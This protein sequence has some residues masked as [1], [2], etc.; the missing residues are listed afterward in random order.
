MNRKI[1]LRKQ[2]LLLLCILALFNIS[3]KL[4]GQSVSISSVTTK[5][6]PSSI[7]CNSGDY[8]TFKVN[9]SYSSFTDASTSMSFLIEFKTASG[10]TWSAVNQGSFSETVSNTNTSGS[11]SKDVDIGSAGSYLLRVTATNGSQTA[12]AATSSVIITVNAPSVFTPYIS[13]VSPACANST[14]NLSANNFHIFTTSNTGWSGNGL[15]GKNFS[16]TNKLPN[17]ISG[18]NS[19]VTYTYIGA[20]LNGC[21]ATATKSV[22]VYPAPNIIASIN[23]SMNQ[24]CKPSIVN[25]VPSNTNTNASVRATGSNGLGTSLTWTIPAPFTTVSTSTVTPFGQDKVLTYNANPS[26]IGNPGYQIGVEGTTNNGC[27]DL[28]PLKTVTVFFRETPEANFTAPAISSSPTVAFTNTTSMVSGAPSSTVSYL[29][30]FGDGSTSTSF[31]PTKTYSTRGVYN[32]TLT[33]TSIVGGCVTT[34]TKVITIGTAPIANFTLP[35]DT[36]L[37]SDGNGGTM[38]NIT[39]TNTTTTNMA[40]NDYLNYQYTWDFGDGTVLTNQTYG[41]SITHSYATS[42]YKTITLTAY[43]PITNLTNVKVKNMNINPHP[44]LFGITDYLKTVGN[45]QGRSIDFSLGFKGVT[46]GSF[47]YSLPTIW[48]MDLDGN[49]T[50]EKSVT[51]TSSINPVVDQVWTETFSTTQ[52]F[53]LKG[54]LENTNTGCKTTYTETFTID[55][56][57]TSNIVK[58]QSV[59]GMCENTTNPVSFSS[60]NTSNISAYDWEYYKTST[61]IWRPTNSSFTPSGLMLEPGAYNINLK[62]KNTNNCWSDPV[63][64]TFSIWDA[65]KPDFASTTV[66]DLFDGATQFTNSTTITGSGGT[67]AYS[68]DFG[69][70]SATSTATNPSYDYSTSGSFNVKLTA[71]ENTNNCFAEKIKAITVKPN[72]SV[73]FNFSSIKCENQ[74]ITFTDISSLAGNT[75]VNREWDWTNDNNIDYTSTASTGVYQ[76]LGTGTYSAKLKATASNGC[77]NT[78]TKSLTINAKPTKPTLTVPANAQGNTTVICYGEDYTLNASP[79][80]GYNYSWFFNNNSMGAVYTPSIS[81]VG[82]DPLPYARPYSV[83]I[84]NA[85]GCFN[86]SDITTIGIKKVNTSLF[87]SNGNN[88]LCPNTTATLSAFVP[89]P[90]QSYTWYKDPYNPTT[91]T[92]SGTYATVGSNTKT[93][94]VD[95]SNEGRYK[96]IATTNIPNNSNVCTDESQTIDIINTLPLTLNYTGVNNID[97]NIPAN[98]NHISSLYP[99]YTIF[100]W[101]RNGILESTNAAFIVRKP[102]K[103]YLIA[104]GDCGVEKSNEVEF[105]YDCNAAYYIPYSGATTFSAPVTS[106]TPT[107]ANT[108]AING[109]WEITSG[110]VLNITNMNVVVTNCSKIKVT[111]GTLNITNCVITGCN[112]WKGLIVEGNSSTINISGSTISNAVIGIGSSNNGNIASNNTQFDNNNMHIGFEPALGT[113]ASVI[114]SSKFG[115]LDYNTASCSHDFYSTLNYN[116]HPMIFADQANGIGVFNNTFTTLN[117]NSSII[118]EAIQIKNSNNVSINNNSDVGFF[119]KGISA[120]IGSN[121]NITNNTFLFRVTPPLNP[122]YSRTAWFNTGIEVKN[123][124]GSTI[125]RNLITDADEGISFYQNTPVPVTVSSILKN[126]IENCTYGL[127]TATKENPAL[128]SFPYQNSSSQ[129]LYVQVNCN[130]FNSNSY[131]WIGTGTYQNQGSSALATGNTF[132]NNANWNVCVASFPVNY[133]I[134]SGGIE[135]IYLT[136]SKPN[137]IMD[138]T[139]YTISNYTTLCFQDPSGTPNACSNRRSTNLQTTTIE[140]TLQT[141]NIKSYAVYPNPVFNNLQVSVKGLISETTYKILVYDLMGKVIYNQSVILSEGEILTIDAKAWSSGMYALQI[142]D[143][144]GKSVHT[145]K[146]VK[147]ISN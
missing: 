130:S 42:G 66:C 143:Q 51:G 41:A 117:T 53:T 28:T 92:F 45:C 71:T 55:P 81:D 87:I 102:G 101:Y 125:E 26:T 34:K 98:L 114:M 47:A 145:Q 12:N 4:N 30:N 48:R 109:D 73:D 122:F 79:S 89:T 134:V 40:D 104:I 14:I 118:I 16:E 32:V 136:G 5:T 121:I 17:N 112:Q 36:C 49:G 64:T 15:S 97:P 1:N 96:Y 131:G 60:S 35:S 138:G 127:V 68:W 100:N 132:D 144:A 29:W 2:H 147:N 72:P 9:F 133:Y 57:P 69:N 6:S 31:S 82:V 25:S 10:S 50:Y 52:T 78:Q 24:I 113:N 43:N 108:I 13:A 76:Y 59:A 84:T 18:A 107:P 3:N 70:A 142:I 111:N 116:N 65:P 11:I 123:I 126:R 46:G 75:I 135:D 27:K 93:H 119:D 85:N 33:A 22:A 67:L 94:V 86:T 39:F 139:T 74:D 124:T 77:Y 62:V 20:D 63:T 54:Q 141:E 88:V 90:A 99:N 83:R 129:T 58:S 128:S 61:S 140:E 38:N 110:A 80:T 8:K 44:E 56:T 105:K 7:T 106:I 19:S 115:E 95:N 120:N 146:I 137:F 91:Q 103:Y 37:K 23:S 21:K